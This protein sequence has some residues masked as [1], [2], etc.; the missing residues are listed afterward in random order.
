MTFFCQQCGE[1]CSVMGGVF[2]VRERVGPFL[3]VLENVYTGERTEVEV[4]SSLRD[5][6]SS[7]ATLPGW[8]DPC[9]FLRFDAAS[10]K[11]VCTVH[12][13]RPSTCRD[14]Q[15]WRVLILDGA[16]RRVGRVM[17]PRFL[18]LEDERLARDWESFRDC[19]DGLPDGEWERA[20]ARFF[21]GKN[22]SV[23]T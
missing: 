1:C 16:G 7:G 22:Y 10:G 21:R 11:S 20:V 6:F 2:A 9:A 3:F 17:E 12:G 19:L 18:H 15:C 5:L 8:E 4:H 14:Y 13:T 23:F